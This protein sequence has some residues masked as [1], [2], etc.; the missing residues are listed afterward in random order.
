[1]SDG[2]S[3]DEGTG[4]DDPNSVGFYSWI[5]PENKVYGDQV[6]ASI[7]GV[8]D[9]ELAAGAPIERVIRYINEGDRQRVA[10]AIHDAIVTGFAYQENYRVT[11]PDGR[12]IDVAA[13]GRCLRDAE[14]VPY[15]YSG[16]VMIQP[17]VAAATDPLEHHCRAALWLATKRRQMLAARYLTSALNVLG[18]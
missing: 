6:I 10:K 4:S 5:V 16:T 11:H 14:G 12:R 7:F 1:M 17:T 13:N 3:A 2:G 8:S 18:K 9:Q 15:I